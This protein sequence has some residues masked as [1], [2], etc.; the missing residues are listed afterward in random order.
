[1]PL[2]VTVGDYV[3]IDNNGNGQQDDGEP[4][5]P[6]VTVTIYDATTNQPVLVD[7]QPY[8][9]VT[10]DDGRYLFTDLPPGDY[11]VVFDLTTLPEGYVP[12]TPNQGND[13]A[14]DSDADPTTGR[15]PPTGFIPSGGQNLTLDLGIRLPPTAEAPVPQ[16]HAPSV[17]FLPHLGH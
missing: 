12:T 15:T 4:G 10:D 1:V 16:P 14:R 17:I 9:V 6:G 11:Y 7:G 2:P 8:Q 13:D 3:W 5:V